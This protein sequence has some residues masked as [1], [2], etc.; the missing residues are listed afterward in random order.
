MKKETMALSELM[1]PMREQSQN[2]KKITLSGPTL[3]SNPMKQSERTRVQTINEDP[4]LTQQQFKDEA[5]INNIM[6][7]YGNDPVAFNA[8]TRK[9][10]V[11]ADFSK[12][13]DYHG[14]LQEV[15]EAQD[16]FASLP[17]QLRSRF[18]NDPGKLLGFLQ[19]PKNY[20]EGV[21]LGLLEAKPQKTT[22]SSTPHVAATSKN[23]SNDKTEAATKNKN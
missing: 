5:D 15:A 19:D 16:A 23:D 11:Y 7:K 21:E 10:G 6:R 14:M 2:V 8:L 13:T 22:Q 17:A 9:G 3:E 4:T 1:T 18:E 20:D 12:I